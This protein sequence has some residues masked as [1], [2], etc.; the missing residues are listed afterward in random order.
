VC[1]H[2][3]CRIVDV[4]TA[5]VVPCGTAGE[6]RA[7]GYA[8]TAG[9]GEDVAATRALVDD[10]GWLRTG[11]LAV[12]AEDGHLTIVGRVKDLIIKGGQNVSPREIEDLLSQHPK[13][14]AAYVVGVPDPTYGEEICAWIEARPGTSPTPQE[15]R[16][17]CRAAIAA[18]KI[19]R[20]VLMVQGE[21][22]FTNTGKVAKY[23]LRELAVSALGLPHSG[24]GAA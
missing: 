11:D 10:H 14:A 24:H 20:Y 6:L 12:M 5:A 9:Y 17:F 1:A 18:S 21:E 13:V 2:I 19:P 22:L 3:E 7:R 8:V 16:R 15:I 4:A 23:R